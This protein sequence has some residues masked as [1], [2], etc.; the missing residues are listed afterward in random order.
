M[1]KAGLA[2]MTA[3]ALLVANLGALGVVGA[4]SRMS[5]SSESRFV[6]K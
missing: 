6:M 1:T 3:R 4:R 5:T 2:S